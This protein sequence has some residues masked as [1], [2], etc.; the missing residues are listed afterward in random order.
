MAQKPICIWTPTGLV[1]NSSPLKAHFPSGSR[2]ECAGLR[3]HRGQAKIVQD[4]VKVLEA[5]QVS[6]PISQTIGRVVELM[7]QMEVDDQ[8]TFTIVKAS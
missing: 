7:L 5:D 8:T 1:C 3:R 6:A 4:V 2:K